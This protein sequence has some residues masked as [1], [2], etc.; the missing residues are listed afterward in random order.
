MYGLRSINNMYAE[1]AGSRSDFL[2][3][4]HPEFNGGKHGSSTGFGKGWVDDP[5]PCHPKTSVA[6]ANV[7]KKGSSSAKIYKRLGIV[8]DKPGPN[9]RERV[10]AR[11]QSAAAAVAQASDGQAAAAGQASLEDGDVRKSF[12]AFLAALKSPETLPS[13]R[14]DLMRVT[15]GAGNHSTEGSGCRRQA[16]FQEEIQDLVNKLRREPAATERDLLRTGSW[17]YYAF[18]LE[19]VRRREAHFHRS[20]RSTL[21]TIKKHRPWL[22]E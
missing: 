6:V 4:G 7:L 14:P 3:V 17:K 9:P 22:L 11:S 2:I 10:L 12:P 18:N 13:F 8:P 1:F 16:A 19:M 5:I 15:Q 21:P 20:A